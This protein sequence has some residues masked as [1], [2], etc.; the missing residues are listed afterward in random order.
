MKKELTPADILTINLNN[1][2]GIKS[3]HSAQYQEAIEYFDKA[4][5]FGPENLDDSLYSDFKAFNI[6]LDGKYTPY[7]YKGFALS[8]LGKHEDAIKCYERVIELAPNSEHA[9]YC[10]GSALLAL[11]QYET[12]IVFHD[13]ALELNPKSVAAQVGKSEALTS[14][15]KNQ[16]VVNHAQKAIE[17]GIESAKVYLEQGMAFLNLGKDKEALNCFEKSIGLNPS[18]YVAHTNK[19]L[20]LG[21]LGDHQSAEKAIKEAIKLN[22]ECEELY[23]LALHE[24]M[25]CIS[26]SSSS[27]IDPNNFEQPLAGEQIKIVDNYQE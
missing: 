20:A 21:N 16:D 24:H 25:Q 1:S 23:T 8:G 3:F 13:K 19:G 15:G 10:K 9:Y 14:L 26:V 6:E 11:G 27:I 5:E 22:P 7:Y 18:D 2:R 17:L 4:I 12:A